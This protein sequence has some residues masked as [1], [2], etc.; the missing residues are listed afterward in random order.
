VSQDEHRLV[1]CPGES[2]A[3]VR[4]IACGVIHYFSNFADKIGG[5]GG[6]AKRGSDHHTAQGSKLTVLG[7]GNPRTSPGTIRHGCGGAGPHN[8]PVY[9]AR[10]SSA[11]D[12]QV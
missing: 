10:G 9:A 12:Q 2:H 7:I 11:L 1:T 4:P 5:G 6:G 8:Y 3:R